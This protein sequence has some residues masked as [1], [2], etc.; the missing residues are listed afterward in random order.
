MSVGIL[1]VLSP[2]TF[3]ASITPKGIIPIN[4]H[5]KNIITTPNMYRHKSCNPLKACLYNPYYKLKFHF[6]KL[7]YCN[8]PLFTFKGHSKLLVNKLPVPK[9]CGKI[10]CFV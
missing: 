8:L 10:L 4:C 3:I 5:A 7:L 1:T 2:N 9:P 6:T